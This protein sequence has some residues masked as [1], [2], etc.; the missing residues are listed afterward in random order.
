MTR[1]AARASTLRSFGRAGLAALA[2]HV[3]RALRRP[4]VR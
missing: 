1:I 4:G 2:F 3:N